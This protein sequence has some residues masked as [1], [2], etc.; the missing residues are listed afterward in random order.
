MFGKLHNKKQFKSCKNFQKRWDATI[1][2]DGRLRC[3]GPELQETW[4]NAQ[5]TVPVAHGKDRQVTKKTDLSRADAEP[6]LR[7]RYNRMAKPH[8]F[9]RNQET[10]RVEKEKGGSYQHFSIFLHLLVLKNGL[11]SS[12]ADSAEHSLIVMRGCWVSTCSGLLILLSPHWLLPGPLSYTLFFNIH[13]NFL[14]SY[15]ICSL[16]VVSLLPTLASLANLS[17]LIIYM[18]ITH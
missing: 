6:D 15:S 12:Q 3:F 8:I 13:Q 11:L 16:G 7:L 18:T 1:T 2:K 5:K 14:N 4:A 17:S 9:M 10:W